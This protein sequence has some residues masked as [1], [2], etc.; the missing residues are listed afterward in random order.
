M[1]DPRFLLRGLVKAKA[2]LALGTLDEC[3]FNC[4]NPNRDVVLGTAAAAVNFKN[5][6]GPVDWIPQ[7]GMTAPASGS[8]NVG[9][10]VCNNPPSPGGNINSNKNLWTYAIY[11]NV[12][13]YN[14]V[15]KL[16]RES[17]TERADELENPVTRILADFDD[18]CCRSTSAPHAILHVW[19]NWFTA[20]R[21]ACRISS[22]PQPLSVMD[23]SC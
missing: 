2:E 19:P 15:L 14:A 6:S 7:T 9:N 10:I 12:V 22:L 4:G 17:K 8:Y 13:Q 21:S 16:R 1:G 18:R 23:L 5:C 11:P 3:A 20:N